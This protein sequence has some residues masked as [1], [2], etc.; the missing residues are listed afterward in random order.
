LVV[1]LRDFPAQQHQSQPENQKASSGS[2]RIP[3]GSSECLVN[4]GVHEL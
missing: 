4:L 2:Y 1:C 3:I